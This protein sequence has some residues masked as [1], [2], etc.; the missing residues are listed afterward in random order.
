[1]LAAEAKI[2]HNS[3]FVRKHA[4]EYCRYG[5]SVPLRLHLSTVVMG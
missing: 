5:V 2:K 3:L 1:M 4:L